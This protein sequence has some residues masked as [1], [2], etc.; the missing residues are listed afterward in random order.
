MLENEIYDI[1]NDFKIL[2]S[3]LSSK[4]QHKLIREF[5]LKKSSNR[6]KSILT[7]LQNNAEKFLNDKS[8][9]SY[10]DGVCLV[11]AAIRLS[12][13]INDANWI[14]KIKFNDIFCISS[15]IGI[16]NKPSFKEKWE[17]IQEFFLHFD[18]TIDPEKEVI[19]MSKF[20]TSAFYLY[21]LG[22]FDEIASLVERAKEVYNKNP[23]DR[24]LTFNYA[25]FL[26]YYSWVLREK[27]RID[28]AKLYSTKV[29]SILKELKSQILVMIYTNL[30]GAFFLH[31]GETEKA[32]SYFKTTK[33]IR[34]DWNDYN[35][36][37]IIL[38]NIGSTLQYQGKY[39]EAIEILEKAY[40]IGTDLFNKQILG[41]INFSIMLNNLSEAY[42]YNGDL[43]SAFN[44]I[45]KA[46]NYLNPAQNTTYVYTEIKRNYFEILFEKQDY[47]PAKKI[48]D[49]F[50]QILSKKKFD[51]I[52]IAYNYGMA[53]INWIEGKFTDANNYYMNALDYA[54]R[55]KDFNSQLK[56]QLRLAELYFTEFSKNSN[57]VALI[58][59]RNFLENLIFA[60]K[61]QNFLYLQCRCLILKANIELI[62]DNYSEA[63]R[64]LKN[65][66]NFTDEHQ[67]EHEIIIKKITEIEK[68]RQENILSTNDHKSLLDESLLQLNN[69]MKFSFN[70]APKKIDIKTFGLMIIDSAGLPV[71]THFL[72]DE[73]K[74]EDII[75]S[76]LISAIN[77][78]S[79]NVLK[80]KE[81]GALKSIQHENINILLENQNERLIVLIAN[82][83]SF[84]LRN[85]ML[86]FSFQANIIKP[87]K[88]VFDLNS[89]KKE[90]DALFNEIFKK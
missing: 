68:I 11:R 42:F 37:F 23:N 47:E 75:I 63:V 16:D 43:N 20:L 13:T 64:I 41:Q 22:F 51:H 21:S 87:Q 88:L 79:Q 26:N 35:G 40:Q 52:L 31:L 58:K 66:L 59:V 70:R 14:S 82:K 24:L 19:E 60:A 61:E 3:K 27:G 2:C 49:D 10:H 15:Q 74:K 76:G 46:V 39:K 90:L 17:I 53:R 48:L 36:I 78:F 55:S 89:K 9:L 85:K 83:D 50:S 86:Q 4:T 54:I 12:L 32:L 57:I 84:I 73:L 65:A 6:F 38:T 71:Y 45:Q 25:L 69:S 1:G 34:D 44:Y 28:E 29:L 7:I 67:K 56:I 5:K 18:Y 80:E 62:Q 30:M 81:I 77:S 33:R 8:T 72:E